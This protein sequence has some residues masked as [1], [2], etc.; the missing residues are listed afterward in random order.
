[1]TKNSLPIPLPSQYDLRGEVMLCYAS[2]QRNQVEYRFNDLGY[3]SDIEYSIEQS[4]TKKIYAWVGSSITNGH[5]IE[6]EKSFPRLVSA[7]EG[8]ECWNFSQGCF[9]TSNQILLEQTEMLV[10]SGAAIDK[11]FIQFINLERQGSKLDVYYNFDKSENIKKFEEIFLGFTEVL[12][13]KSWYWMLMDTLVHEI[14]D[15]ILNSSNKIA[16]N[17]RFIDTTGIKE[18]PGVK[19]HLGLSQLISKKI[20]AAIP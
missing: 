20:N 19:T 13:G 12:K 6:V 3:R 9:R 7:A 8:A 18:H 16:H 11:F 1:M 15:W 4:H 2:D 10:N 17:P 14:P 5:T